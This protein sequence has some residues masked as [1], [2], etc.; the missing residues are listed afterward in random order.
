MSTENITDKEIEGGFRSGAMP[1]PHDPRDRKL[2]D[3]ALGAPRMTQEDWERGYDIEKVLNVTIPI[4]DQKSSLSCVGQGWVYDSASF[5]C[6][7]TGRYDM[8]SARAI[9]SKIYLPEGG[10]FLRDGGM[11]LVNYGPVPEPMA[12][13]KR[14]N[15]SVDEAWMRDESWDTPEVAEFAKALKFA[16]CRSV[17]SF[18]IDDFAMAIR[19]NLGMVFGV[20]GTNNGT[21]GSNEPKPPLPTTPQGSLWG[22]CLFGGKYG[23]DELGK[24]IATPNSWGARRKDRLHPDGWQKLRESWFAENG[25]WLFSPWLLLDKTN[26]IYMTPAEIQKFMVDFDLKFIR[27][28][29]T[30]AMG[31]IIAKKLKVATGKDRSALLLM[32][33]EVRKGGK[34]VTQEIWDALPKENF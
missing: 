31:Q 33:N 12:P 13:S 20:V 28:Q 7:K 26:N 11:Q 27:N 14:P 15:G 9:Y 22:H 2:E 5:V 17:L 23:I 3:I 8:K 32:E 21:W 16:E 34:G 4:Q 6:S 25:R 29:E 18:S 30:G 10:A 1:D 19:D 24:F